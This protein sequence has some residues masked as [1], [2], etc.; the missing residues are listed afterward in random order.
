MKSIFVLGVL[1]SST[2]YSAAAD[3]KIAPSTYV[4]EVSSNLD[5]AQLEIEMVSSDRKT[6]AE[7]V[8]G[9]GAFSAA[10]L[11]PGDYSFG[12]I[13][14]VDGH[15]GTESFDLLSQSA[16]PISLKPGQAYFGGRLVIQEAI[17]E[18][19]SAPNVLDNCIRGT[20]RF[21]KEQSDDCRDGIGVDGERAVA[22][23]V[24]LYA[25]TLK[26]SEIDRV[27]SALNATEDQ[28][29]YMPIETAGG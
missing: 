25:P 2:V 7:L 22:K 6:S 1:L 27:R 17:D 12:T 13:T 9:T 3:T 8:F 29:I 15:R 26:Q 24:S 19:A 21:R 23:S 10:E 5:C 16:A 14:C 4:L 18:T 28:L 11:A 20:S